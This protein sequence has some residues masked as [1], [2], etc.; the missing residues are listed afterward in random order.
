MVQV[1][2]ITVALA[3]VIRDVRVH[4]IMVVLVVGQAA[5]IPVEMVVREIVCIVVT[6]IVPEHATKIV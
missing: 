5:Q 1:A 4:V 6:E 3:L 2:V